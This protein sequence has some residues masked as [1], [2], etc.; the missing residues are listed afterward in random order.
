MILPPPECKVHAP[1]ELAEAMVH[2]LA[3]KPEDEWLEIA[4]HKGHRYLTACSR[5]QERILQERCL[6]VGRG[7]GTGGRIRKEPLDERFLRKD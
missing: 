6:D 2:A 3:P 4:V 1:S 7:K 5:A